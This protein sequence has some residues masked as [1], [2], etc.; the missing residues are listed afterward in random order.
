MAWVGL[1]EGPADPGVRLK[2]GEKGLEAAS[3][4]RGTLSHLQ[5]QQRRRS[6][7]GK[8]GPRE[9]PG[10]SAIYNGSEGEDTGPVLVPQELLEEFRVVGVPSSFLPPSPPPQFRPPQHQTMIF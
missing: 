3:R 7:E 1:R 8:Q 9:R 2:S 6:T 4:V 10:D 5:A